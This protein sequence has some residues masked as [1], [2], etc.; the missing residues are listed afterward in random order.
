MKSHGLDK[1]KA[2]QKDKKPHLSSKP[3]EDR[4]GFKE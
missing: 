1:V 3:K 2:V 4:K